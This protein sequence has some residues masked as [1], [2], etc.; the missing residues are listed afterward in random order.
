MN[1]GLEVDDQP[2]VE[3]ESLV[4][5][6]ISFEFSNEWIICWDGYSYVNKC[7]V[8]SSNPYIFLMNV[9]FGMG[10]HTLVEE[11]YLVVISY[12]LMNEC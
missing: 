1:M 3:A 12:P 7:G 10:A 11:G 5:I 9:G 8:S 6:S 2:R 4:T